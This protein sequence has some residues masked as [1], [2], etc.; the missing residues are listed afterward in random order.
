MTSIVLEP[1]VKE[2]LLADCKDFIQSEDW[3]VSPPALGYRTDRSILYGTQVRGE[4]LDTSSDPQSEMGH[5]TD[6]LSRYSFPTRISPARR[7][8]KVRS[9]GT[10]HFNLAY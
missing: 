9:R 5:Q 6:I 4:R 2:M 1:G 10:A 8:R 3:Y 7:S